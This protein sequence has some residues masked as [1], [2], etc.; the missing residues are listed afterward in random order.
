MGIFTRQAGSLQSFHAHV[1]RVRLHECVRGFRTR[2]LKAGLVS[3]AGPAL[4]AL[5]GSNGGGRDPPVKAPPRA[6]NFADIANMASAR[7]P[8]PF[9]GPC[10]APRVT[11]GAAADDACSVPISA[12]IC[13]R[14][15]IAQ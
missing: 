12:S 14:L 15:R 7:S 8:P 11:A 10:W 3:Q 2:A 4:P 13:G 1:T 5:A 6:S 9:T